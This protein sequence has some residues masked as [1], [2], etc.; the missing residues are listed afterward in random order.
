MKK[1]IIAALATAAALGT[2]SVAPAA[3]VG[4]TFDN[5]GQCEAFLADARNDARKA[6]DE[7]PGQFN[8]EYKGDFFCEENEDGTFT[9]QRAE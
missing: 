9:T 1:V 3:H 6:S 8:K 2:A 4:V 7:N 5:R